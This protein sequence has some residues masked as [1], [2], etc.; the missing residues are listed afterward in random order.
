MGGFSN[1]LPSLGLTL[2]SNLL[3]FPE[4]L[5]KR[6]ER[7]RSE[8]KRTWNLSLL[9]CKPPYFTP[10][11]LFL[12]M[13]SSSKPSSIY[14]LLKI[15]LPRIFPSLLTV[16][17]FLTAVAKFYFSRTLSVYST[18]PN[19]PFHCLSRS[20]SPSFLFLSPLVFLRSL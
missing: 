12:P 14:G 18:P 4:S 15:S 16:P 10:A 19:L 8:K 13:Y 1:V 17:S 11:F 5:A 20:A 3:A 7:K 9:S 6:G 2:F